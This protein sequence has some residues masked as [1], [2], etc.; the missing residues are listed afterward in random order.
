MNEQASVQPMTAKRSIINNPSPR[1]VRG[2]LLDR[3]GVINRDLPH[4]ILR[5]EDF[6]IIP[7]SLEAMARLSAAGLILAVVTNQ[8]NIGRGLVARAAVDAMHADLSARVAAAGGR[9]DLFFVCESAD[10]A[11]PDRKPNP[12]LVFKALHGC[13]L[14]SDAAWLVG[15]DARD[16]VAAQAAGVAPALVLTGKGRMVQASCSQVPAFADLAAFA[17]HILRDQKL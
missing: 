13:G 7:G 4:G 14:A 11:H 16:I 5:L 10:P 9:L 2:V 6:H 15:D 17:D 12:G 8:A 3:D 1:P